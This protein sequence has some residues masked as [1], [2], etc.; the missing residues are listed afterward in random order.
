MSWIYGLDLLGVF[1]FA[2]SGVLTA[3]DNKFDVV[4]AA[5]IGM[6]TAIG[7]GTLR[8][9]LIGETPVGWMKD[10]NYLIVVLV[11]LIISYL[12]K[13]H[14]I[15]LK[16][17]MFFFDTIGI[18]LFTILGIQKTM[19][20]GLDPIIALLMG[21]VTAVFGGV[22]R[23]VLTNVVPLIF[24]KEIYASACLAGGIS[25]LILSRFSNHL[26]FNLVFTML[27]V[28]VIRYLSV[29]FKWTLRKSTSED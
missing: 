16:R 1:V 28:V 27:I 13:K 3:I 22:L 15:Q 11:A 7:G 2:I 9:L 20:L 14:I 21:V 26:N 19:E 18:G 29:K 5:I 8:D 25:F 23:D 17:S 12:F 4:G 6:V 10:M 24:R